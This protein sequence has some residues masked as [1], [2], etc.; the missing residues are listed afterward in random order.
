[1]YSCA[2][3]RTSGAAEITSKT[4]PLRP[5]SCWTR[6]TG[7]GRAPAIAMPSAS[8]TSE[9]PRPVL[10]PD[11]GHSASAAR[12]LRKDTGTRTDIPHTSHALRTGTVRAPVGARTLRVRSAPPGR[13]P[14]APPAEGHR[15]HSER[16]SPFAPA[17][18][19]GPPLCGSTRSLITN[20]LT[21]QYIANRER[22]P[23]N[24]QTK[25]GITRISSV[26]ARSVGSCWQICWMRHNAA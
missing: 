5:G 21:D 18:D 25:P 8:C 15:Y 7:R 13:S 26:C 1:M 24:N 16:P 11:R 2:T 17:A 10:R 9:A 23:S 6:R 20:A 22:T 19:G 12:R 14:T 3:L 4:T